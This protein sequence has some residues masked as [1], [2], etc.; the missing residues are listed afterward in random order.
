MHAIEHLP[1]LIEC[2]NQEWTLKQTIDLENDD[3]SM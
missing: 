3:M 2:V 1:R